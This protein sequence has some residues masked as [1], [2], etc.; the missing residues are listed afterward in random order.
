[1]IISVQ[2]F[3]IGLLPAIFYMMGD[4]VLS[5]KHTSLICE[6]T[7][8]DSSTVWAK[9]EIAISVGL[10]MVLII[11]SLVIYNKTPRTQPQRGLSTGLGYVISGLAII[12]IV[13]LRIIG[14]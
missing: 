7:E 12:A 1:M 14:V 3:L 8:H 13:I 6:N 5:W 9:V 2:D 11:I 10:I 4:G